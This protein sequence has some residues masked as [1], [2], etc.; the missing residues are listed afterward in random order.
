[1]LENWKTYK[2]SELTSVITKGTTPSTYGFDF[3][4]SG[5]TYIRAQSLNYD[6]K[7]DEEA[8]SFIS[9]EAHEKLKRS[10][11]QSG[12]I[13]FSMAGAYL[14]MVGMVKESFC[15]ANTNQAVGIIRINSASVN[16]KFVEYALRNPSMIS[17][18]NSQSGQS[19]QPNINL[20]EIGNLT[21]LAPP[22]AEQIA[23]A[24]ILSALDDK[25]E[26]NLQINKTLEEMAMA[27][28]KH[29]FVDFGPFQ[30]GKFVDSELGMIPE[31]WE[32]KSLGD[33]IKHQKGFAFKSQWYQEQ[34]KRVVRVSDTTANSI[35]LNTC[36]KIS[37]Q[38]A[39]NYEAYELKTNDIIIA[40][41]GS[42]PPNYSSVVGKVIRVPSIAE[43]ALLNQ[44]AVKLNMN[45][46]DVNQ[47]GLLYYSLKTDR[48]LNYIV[49]SAQGSASQA[50]I[51][52]TDIFNYPIPFEK[53]INFSEFS[54][55]IE[56]FLEQQNSLIEENQTLTTL[57][58]TLLPQLI[59][60]E[61]RVKDVEKTILESL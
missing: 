58:D 2:L 50:S 19:A 13:L 4:E 5:I 23:I 54:N 31:G 12:D 46:D 41:V 48:F 56:N 18:V 22:L 9:Q 40:T 51:K 37:D 6:G 17:Y 16:S 3:E 49:N 10:Q 14:G 15:P 45:I 20:A 25:I 59:S 27:L 55:Q 52:L 29:W 44:N 35:D 11:L 7:V 26:L 57:R 47:Q 38:L 30:N 43:G 1:M 39:L 21:I 32:V 24:S 53:N 61:V 36:H 28:Y 33:F 60:G 34:G 8:F 42:W